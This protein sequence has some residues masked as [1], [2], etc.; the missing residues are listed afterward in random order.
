MIVNPSSDPWIALLLGQPLGGYQLVNCIGVGGFG[1]V[2]EASHA[3]SGARVAIKVLKHGVAGEDVVDF[4]NEGKLLRRLAKCNG[5]IKYI[6]GGIEKVQ[7]Q[8]IVGV[9][10]PVDVQYH[11]LPIASGSVDELILDA[12]ARKNLAWVD[13]VGIWRDVVV[14]VKQMH[15]MGVAHRDLKSSNCL[16]MVRGSATGV[17]FADMGSAKDLS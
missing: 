15:E 16:L 7:L 6:E 2:F 17:R 13:R 3:Q 1:Y 12:S 11:V 9:T 14:T 10:V 8:S 5:V 4:E